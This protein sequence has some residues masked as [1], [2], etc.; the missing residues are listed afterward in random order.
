MELNVTYHGTF[1]S[2]PVLRHFNDFIRTQL[3]PTKVLDIFYDWKDD[4]DYDHYADVTLIVVTP[5]GGIQQVDGTFIVTHIGGGP[6]NFTLH[7][8]DVHRVRTDLPELGKCTYTLEQLQ[9][10]YAN[11]DTSV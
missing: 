9:E 7:V 10:L 6:F 1:P 3:Y 5:I 2:N 4:T 8:K 11:C